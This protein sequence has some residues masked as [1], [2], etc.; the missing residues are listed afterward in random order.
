MNV[1]RMQRT[2]NPADSMKIR[3]TDWEWIRLALVSHGSPNDAYLK[4]G[5][6]GSAD[7]TV[8]SPDEESDK[9]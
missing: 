7:T 1:M 4:V 2:H 3:R 6:G 8:G 9:T 5:R